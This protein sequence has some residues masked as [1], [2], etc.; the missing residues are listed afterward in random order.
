MDWSDWDL[1]DFQRLMIAKREEMEEK[2]KMFSAIATYNTL[3]E[4]NLLKQMT[5]GIDDLCSQ[6]K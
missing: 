3:K 6:Y 5:R 4:K 1:F 2:M